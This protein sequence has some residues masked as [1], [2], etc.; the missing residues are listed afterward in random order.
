MPIAAGNDSLVTRNA[1]RRDVGLPS[2]NKHSKVDRGQLKCDGTRA[3]TRFRLSENRTNPFKSAGA[4]VHSTTGS[5]VVRISGSNAVY[6]M[7]RGSVKGTWLPTPFANFPFTSPPARHRV[8]SH[9]N[10]SLAS[11][12]LRGYTPLLHDCYFHSGN[13]LIGVNSLAPLHACATHVA[14]HTPSAWATSTS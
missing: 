9:F 1:K 6:T 8:P 10:W 11:E 7:F 14:S 4:S 5:R 12:G 3:E 2:N 13:T